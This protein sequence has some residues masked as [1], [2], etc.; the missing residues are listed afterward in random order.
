MSMLQ[1][2]ITQLRK[3]PAIHDWQVEINR[4]RSHQRFL[5]GEEVESVRTLETV[6]AQ[7]SIYNDH[8]SPQGNA[9]RGEA[10]FVVLPQDG[11]SAI[12]SKLDDAV[13]MAGLVSNPPFS[14]PGPSD[15]PLVEVLDLRLLEEPQVVAEE[16]GDSLIAAARREDGVRLS[17]S[18]CF[19]D[20]QERELCNSRGI[21]TAVRGSHALFDFE[22]ISG[23]GQKESE[24]HIDLE[25]RRA[26]DFDVAALVARKAAEARDAARAVVPA[27]HNGPVVISREALLE[28]LDFFRFQTSGQS[29]FQKA[30]QLEM[31]QSVFGPRE[32]RGEPLT[33]RSDALL[34]FGLNSGPFD[35][36]G[37]PGLDVTVVQDNVL[38][39]FWAGQR[40]AEYLGIEPTGQFGN[41][42]M[43]PGSKPLGELLAGGPL[44]HIVAFS[45]LEPDPITGDVVAEVRLG[46]AIDGSRRTPIKGGALSCNVYDAFAHAAYA[47]EMMFQGRYEGPEAI[48]FGEMVVAGE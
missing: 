48:R 28:L 11:P 38:M 15:Y 46:Y 27:R 39:R 36:E 6:R 40:Y 2:I 44:L 5:V 8:P 25:R 3:H 22:L 29:K 13:F 45:S 4:T 26:A 12:A 32:V 1:P 19:L 43:P 24:V 47:R 37:L 10:S 30:T 7:V 9:A 42:V 31:G 14:L 41:L 20:V 21:E 18:E 17:A 34:P 16:L 33:L 35:A 23:D